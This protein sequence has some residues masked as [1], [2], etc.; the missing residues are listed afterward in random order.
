MELSF[1]ITSDL[2]IRSSLSY[3][4]N[5]PFFKIIDR[6]GVFIIALIYQIFI[7]LINTDFSE[8]LKH[9]AISLIFLN[10]I[11]YL[12]C[13]VLGVPTYYSLKSGYKS[14][15]AKKIN[16][17]PD[18]YFG[19]KIVTLDSDGLTV[20][21]PLFSLKQDWKLIDSFVS[22]DDFIHIIGRNQS[23]ITSIPKSSLAETSDYVDFK[24]IFD[25]NVSK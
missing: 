14:S 10:C 22:H 16:K 20:E 8:G 15:I 11:L 2:I 19:M 1:E 18:E 7:I 6:F 17:L 12:F 23:R 4:K 5:I 9:N 21:A 3:T 25:D 24:K 13:L